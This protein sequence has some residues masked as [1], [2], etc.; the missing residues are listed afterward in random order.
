M[1]DISAYHMPSQKRCIIWNHD[2]VFS[3]KIHESINYPNSIKRDKLL[4]P[5]MATPTNSS[6]WNYQQ[7]TTEF[8]KK[9]TWTPICSIHVPW[10]QRDL[11]IKQTSPTFIVNY[12]DAN[13]QHSVATQQA[14]QIIQHMGKRK[15]LPKHDS[16]TLITI[17]CFVCHG[18][19]QMINCSI[20]TW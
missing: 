6:S 20:H 15:L 8:V 12:S 2:F 1:S 11:I 7:E 10:Q 14:N 19:M 4:N 18:G 13:E 3:K 16:S 5:I 17:M 9:K